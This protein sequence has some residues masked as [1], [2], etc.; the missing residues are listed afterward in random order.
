M[1]SQPHHHPGLKGKGITSYL[2][3]C[4]RVLK[5]FAAFLPS[6]T[7][8][9]PCSGI[10]D[11][12][13]GKVLVQKVAGHS[14]YRGSFSNG[15]RSLSLPRWRESFLVSG[16]VLGWALPSCSPTLSAEQQWAEGEAASR[17]KHLVNHYRPSLQHGQE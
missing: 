16:T 8:F 7:L 5:V 4:R 14:G 2:L 12:T 1:T 10:I 13:G 17:F 6:H 9:P 11:N 15:V 3:H